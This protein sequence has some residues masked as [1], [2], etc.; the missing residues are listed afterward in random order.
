[1]GLRL[2]FI[3]F[4]A[5]VSSGPLALEEYQSAGSG[6]HFEYPTG[7]DIVA[8]TG[9]E[10][11]ISS[12]KDRTAVIVF[13]RYFLEQATQIGNDNELRE[14][15]A[16]LYT[17]M[18]VPFDDESE[19]EFVRGENM[20]SFAADYTRRNP[21]TG[22]EEARHIK[23]FL[24]R[25][26]DDGQVLYFTQA[27]LPINASKRLQNKAKAVLT[28]FRITE[29]ID[30]NVYPAQREGVAMYVL[31]VMALTAFFYARNRRIQRS[32]N[33]LGRDSAYFWRCPLCRRV[34]HVDHDTCRRCG[35]SRPNV[36]SPA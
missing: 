11:I 6:I 19:I 21:D 15:L 20:I 23:G 3:S 16:G 25:T 14:A 1:M 34:N 7:W 8:D 18:E 28:T 5:M 24:V 17:L 10:V 13:T 36:Q 22:I 2:L 30:E 26:A 29:P 35:T 33:P 27:R 9:G 4:L 31:L 12:D 32:K